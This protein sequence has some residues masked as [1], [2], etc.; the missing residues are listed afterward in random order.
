MLVPGGRWRTR[1]GDPLGTLLVIKLRGLPRTRTILQRRFDAFLDTFL[2]GVVDPR[3]RYTQRSMISASLL[4]AAALSRIRARV[5]LRAALF[6][7]RNKDSSSSFS[8]S[9]SLTR[10][11]I[12]GMSVSSWLQCHIPSTFHAIRYFIISIQID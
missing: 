8:S 4:P 10:Y 3:C 7:L 12:A 5:C 9:V 6:P 1:Q 11:L 2:P